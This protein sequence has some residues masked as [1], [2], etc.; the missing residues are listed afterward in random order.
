MFFINK[1]T[2]IK[3]KNLNTNNIEVYRQT[4]QQDIIN[5][6]FDLTFSP[7]VEDEYQ[8]IIIDMGSGYSRWLI[9]FIKKYKKN[10]SKFIIYSFDIND[11]L[12]EYLKELSIV[13]KQN[14]SDILNKEIKNIKDDII[15]VGTYSIY[16]KK[17]LT[18]EKIDLEDNCVNFIY[19]R[20][21]IT[22]YNLKQ[23]D[24]I[25]QEIYRLL[26]PGKYA[27]FVEYDF[28]IKNVKESYITNIINE[29]LDKKFKEININT[30]YNKIKKKFNNT[31]H[32]I[33][34]IPLYDESMF[35]CTCIHNMILGYSHFMKDIIDILRNKHNIS[36]TYN[37]ISN[38]LIAE[39]ETNKSYIELY[40]ISVEK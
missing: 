7:I 18:K 32:V 6:F 29:Y 36:L 13:E 23:W 30:I 24:N 20:D 12:G 33:K 28:I 3:W 25:I 15:E 11:I 8:N 17:D 34:Q 5:K 35:N 9:N 19:H 31:K 39:W 10:I 37:D 26:K 21:M 2:L 38:I 27:E 40:F 22:V 1:T 4:I 14:N 16:I